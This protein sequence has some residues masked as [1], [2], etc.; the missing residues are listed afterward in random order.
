[1][2]T[3]AAVEEHSDDPTHDEEEV[4]MKKVLLAKTLLEFL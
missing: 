2:T 4:P 1:M 3:I